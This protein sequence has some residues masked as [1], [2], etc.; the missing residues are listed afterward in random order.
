[1]RFSDTAFTYR[2]MGIDN[3]SSS[4]GLA[5]ADL[6]LRQG[7]YHLH[8]A[9]TFLA[10]RLLD[11]HRGSGITHGARWARQ[12]TLYDCVTDELIYHNPHAVAVETPFFMPRR[13]QSFETLTEMMIFIRLAVQ[14]HYLTSDIYR[15]TPGEAKRAV[16][17]AKFTMKKAVIKDC[18]L[19]LDTITYNKDIQLDNLTEHEYDAIAVIVAHGEKI[20]KETGFVK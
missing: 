3:G 9:K 2:I 11:R 7:T 18:I 15:V 5:V 4:L 1:M 10:E 13:V 14:A 17:P 20:R 16:Q 12:N 6:D 8:Y 19:S